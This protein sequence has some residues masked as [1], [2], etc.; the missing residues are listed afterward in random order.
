MNSF[1]KTAKSNVILNGKYT[2]FFNV[3]EVVFFNLKSNEIYQ[4][5]KI[6]LRFLK[7]KY[8]EKYADNLEGTV[9]PFLSAHK[10]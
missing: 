3:G 7:K 9:N 5:R 4:L 6:Y 2:L 10:L 1:S 8:H